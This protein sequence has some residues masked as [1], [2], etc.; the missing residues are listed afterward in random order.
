MRMERV[1]SELE[2]RGGWGERGEEEGGKEVSFSL[3]YYTHD[4]H[5]LR[6]DNPS[7]LNP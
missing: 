5:S 7:T 6:S 1:L 3:F 4:L 2:E